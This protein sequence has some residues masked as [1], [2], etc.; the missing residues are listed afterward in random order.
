LFPPPTLFHRLYAAEARTRRPADGDTRV[1]RI[2]RFHAKTTGVQVQVAA[3]ASL[4]RSNNSL[5]VG[6]VQWFNVLW[7]AEGN[8]GSITWLFLRK[9]LL[10]LCFSG[11]FQKAGNFTR[12]GVPHCS[13]THGHP[14][15]CT[16]IRARYQNQWTELQQSSYDQESDSV[17]LG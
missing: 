16:R 13:R 6:N 5:S 7:Q 4:N 17:A 8:E 12:S 11:P 10:N 9:S 14:L 15:Q 1:V 3:H 2:T